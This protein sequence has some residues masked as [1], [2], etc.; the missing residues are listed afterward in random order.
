MDQD[1]GGKPSR[2]A[3]ERFLSSLCWRVYP[4]HILPS[5]RRELSRPARHLRSL[6]CSWWSTLARNDALGCRTTFTA[7]EARRQTEGS[8]RRWRIAPC[9]KPSRGRVEGAASARRRGQGVR[10]SRSRACARAGAGA[11]R[12]PHTGPPARPAARHSGRS[13]VLA[14]SRR[15]GRPSQRID[16]NLLL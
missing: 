12:A 14:R 13:G 5:P 10:T 15:C 2:W 4:C 9:F 1:W 7:A 6:C 16:F 11:R 8:A 3:V